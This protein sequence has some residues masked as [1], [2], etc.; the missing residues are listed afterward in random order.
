[1]SFKV[2]NVDP[3]HFGWLV[4]RTS[5]NICTGFRALAVVDEGDVAPCHHCGGEHPRIK[6]MVGY[7]D[8]TD[9][10]VAMHVALDLM[11]F[12][13]SERLAAVKAL[14]EAAFEYPFKQAGRIFALGLT[15]ASNLPAL[16]LARR[17]GFREVYRI[18]DGWTH[19]EDLILSRVEASDV[20]R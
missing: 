10:G 3:M 7:S 14:R 19:G 16:R 5:V 8:W 4:E 6:G 9:T 20:V 13:K 12:P 15:R 1:M 2:M 17:L 18:A 11:A